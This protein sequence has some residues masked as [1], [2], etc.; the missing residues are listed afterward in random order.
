MAAEDKAAHKATELKGKA[1]E[2]VGD[3]TDNDDLKAEGQADQVEGNVKQ[4]G[5]KVKD[6][7]NKVKNAVTG[8]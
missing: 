4:A 3:V 2:A 7:G 1:K 8:K 5:D 6:A